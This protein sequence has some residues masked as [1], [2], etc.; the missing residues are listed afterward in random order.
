MLISYMIGYEQ[1]CRFSETCLPLADVDLERMVIGFRTKGRKD[2]VAEFPLSPRLVPMFRKMKDEGREHTFV[3]PVGATQR[4]SAFFRRI[5]LGHLCFHCTRVTFVTRCEEAGLTAEECMRLVGHS[6]YQIHKTYRRMRADHRTV[7]ANETAFG[8]AF[9][10]ILARLKAILEA[11]DDRF[12]GLCSN[13]VALFST[14]LPVLTI[15]LQD[16]TE[17]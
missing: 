11:V 4:W 5:G 3:M 8:N 15:L 12:S 7:Q 13:S 14:V 9:T 16:C 10:G 1:G 17:E 6:S 2:S